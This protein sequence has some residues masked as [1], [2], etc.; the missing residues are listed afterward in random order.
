[1]VK[2]GIGQANLSFAIEPDAV[3]TE[4]IDHITHAEAKQGAEQLYDEV[5][6]TAEDIAEV[7]A[8][9]IGRPRRMTL[10]EIPIRPTTQSL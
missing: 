7:I 4:L 3:A 5:A 1:M 2:L 10:N 9:A 6:I 8:F